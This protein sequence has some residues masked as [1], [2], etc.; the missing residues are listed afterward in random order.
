MLTKTLTT[1]VSVYRPENESP[2]CAGLSPVG[3]AG[4]EPATP[5][6]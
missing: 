3:G 2:A 5:C 1:T 6:L 4:L